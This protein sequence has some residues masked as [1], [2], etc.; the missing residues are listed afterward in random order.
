VGEAEETFSRNF[1]KHRPHK[2][3]KILPTKILL[4]FFIPY[5]TFPGLIA[6]VTNRPHPRR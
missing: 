6:I 1:P 5:L 4:V 3:L 2:T